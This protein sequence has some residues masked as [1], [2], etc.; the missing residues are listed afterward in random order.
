MDGIIGR[1]VNLAKDFEAASIKRVRCMICDTLQNLA[2]ADRD[3]LRSAINNPMFSVRVILDVCA[4][5]GVTVN[6]NG[7]YKHRHGRCKRQ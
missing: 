7:I 6:E 3:A 5:N 1:Q 2:P 4:Q